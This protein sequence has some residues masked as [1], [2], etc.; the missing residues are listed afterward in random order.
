M[1]ASLQLP[2]RSMF[3]SESSKD[4]S[5]PQPLSPL[6][7]EAHTLKAALASCRRPLNCCSFCPIL[8]YPDLS[9]IWSESLPLGPLLPWHIIDISLYRWET[10][11]SNL[12]PGP[13]GGPPFRSGPS[14][15]GL[16]PKQAWLPQLSRTLRNNWSS[17]LPQQPY[18]SHLVTVPHSGWTTFLLLISCFFSS[19]NVFT[20]KAKEK[21]TFVYHMKKT[22]LL[23]DSAK[24]QTK[25]K[26][27]MDLP[28]ATKT[29]GRRNC[30]QPPPPTPTANLP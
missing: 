6:P 14:R 2:L 17:P 11:A 30:P 4:M 18:G 1:A 15:A 12:T 3:L 10:E 25:K 29:K 19:R 22:V 24:P 28:I 13:I 8:H 21:A 9:G 5:V 23:W 26:R 16:L 7:P 20:V 27:K